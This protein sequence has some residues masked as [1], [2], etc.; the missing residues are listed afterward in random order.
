MAITM[1]AVPT[2]PPYTHGTECFTHRSLMRYRVEKVSVAALKRTN[3][4]HKKLNRVAAQLPLWAV[5]TAAHMA[6]VSCRTPP[7]DAV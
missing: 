3:A 1:P 2:A 5:S 6:R 7:F 4:D